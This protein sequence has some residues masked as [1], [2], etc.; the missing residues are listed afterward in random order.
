VPIVLIY[1]LR[2]GVGGKSLSQVDGLNRRKTSGRALGS[3]VD[4]KKGR[5][6]VA[7]ITVHRSVVE[8]GRAYQ[9][10]AEGKGRL[11]EGGKR[12]SL[13]EPLNE[14]PEPHPWK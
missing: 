7:S 6:A 3:I 12:T 1:L 5:C 8:G 2:T 11:W 13:S 10:D 14:R 9:K 4:F